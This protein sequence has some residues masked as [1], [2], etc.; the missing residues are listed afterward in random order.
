[1]SRT[2][3]RLEMA[4]L[5]NATARIPSDVVYRDFMHETVMLNLGTGKYHGLN[6]TGGRMLR[7]L[8]STP[9]LRAA[10]RV[11]ADDYGQPL[12]R[13]ERD[14]CTFCLKLE[15]RGLIALERDDGC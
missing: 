14:L 1:M 10:A 11:L 8:E 3:G 9:H 15:E 7:V 5:L 12:E 4:E 6:P 13:V 2:E